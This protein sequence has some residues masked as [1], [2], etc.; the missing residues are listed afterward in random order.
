MLSQYWELVTVSLYNS[1]YSLFSSPLHCQYS[2]SVSVQDL[3]CGSLI[4]SMC[5]GFTEL[6]VNQIKIRESRGRYC[7][8]K[9]RLL[10]K[11]IKIISILNWHKIHKIFKNSFGRIFKLSQHI[12]AKNVPNSNLSCFLL[13]KLDKIMDLETFQWKKRHKGSNWYN[14]F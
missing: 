7:W 12:V 2:F 3:L 5:K 10:S 1:P 6:K 8:G 4:F 13:F 9:V 14:T 11:I